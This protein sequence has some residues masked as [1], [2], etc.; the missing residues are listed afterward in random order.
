MNPNN[1][2]KY[3]VA[4]YITAYEDSEAVKLCLESL[5]SQS[6]PVQKILIIDNS[7]ERPLLY[8]QNKEHIIIK[9]HPENIGISAGLNWAI[10]WSIEQGY[11]FLW[12]FDQDS[13]PDKDC[14]SKLLFGYNN[15]HKNDYKIGIIAPLAIDLRNN[16]I[17][18]AAKFN[19]YRFIGCKPENDEE[20]CECDS[21]ITSGSLISLTAIKNIPLPIK[22]LFIDGVD[23]DYGLQLRQKGFHNLI[24]PQANLY[25]EL[26][27]PIKI[28]FLQKE[29]YIQQYS[30]FRQYYISRNH[31][32]LEI[33][34]AKG[35]YRLYSCL[36]RIKYMLFTILWIQLYDTQD[37]GLKIWAC[38]LGTY[39]GFIG[40]L[41]K[42]WY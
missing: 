22:D 11:D 18:E 30:A 1:V 8:L 36:W 9:F 2:T 31:T 33:R 21:P 14:L 37:K 10:S 34:Y 32:Y 23:M 15:F 38:L 5:G 27:S 26:G 25:H 41:G 16:Q 28:S 35:F 6:F 20:Y 12:T 13:I 17:V 29:F 40:K 39:D 7:K 24:L 42:I 19:K 4:T 3:K